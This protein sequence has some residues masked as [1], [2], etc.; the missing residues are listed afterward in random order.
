MPSPQKHPL[1]V[2]TQQEAQVLSRITKADSERVDTVRRANALLA[3]S[4]GD[5]FP[6]AA[7]RSGFKSADS[8]SQLVQR[9]H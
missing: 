6:L 1:R 4:A 5:P 3:V 8:V 9:F 2:F 7:H